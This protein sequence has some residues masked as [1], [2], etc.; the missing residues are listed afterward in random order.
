[1]TEASIFLPWPD[2]RLSPNARQHWASLAR[3]KRQAKQE[4]YYTAI[5]AGLGKIE[6]ETVLVR[7]SFYPPSRRAYDLDNLVA[8]MKA[9]A[10]GIAMAIGIDD[11][12]W[13]LAVSP[14]GPVEKNG[15]VKVDIEWTEVAE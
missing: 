5:E 6:A 14:R 2:R 8:S 4:A 10:D 7:Y 13:N 1:M 12:R 15:M 11:S 9:A 3:A